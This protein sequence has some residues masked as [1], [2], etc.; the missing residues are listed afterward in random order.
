MKALVYWCRWHAARLRLQGRSAAMVWGEL[1]F[2]DETARFRYWLEEAVLLIEEGR[3]AGR[4]Q[5]DEMG[6]EQ[7]V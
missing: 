4:K 5:L 1:V 7:V 2:A 3:H 6:V